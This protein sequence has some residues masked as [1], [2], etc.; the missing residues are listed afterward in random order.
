MHVPTARRATTRQSRRA[1]YASY[2]IAAL[3]S[4]SIPAEEGPTGAPKAITATAH[5]LARLVYSM[6][7]YGQEYQDTGAEYRE[8]QCQ[9]RALRTAKRRAVKLGYQPAPMPHPPI[10]ARP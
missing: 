6:L 7:R 5:K 2:E 9:Q 8:T 3:H 10:A 4:G 1:E